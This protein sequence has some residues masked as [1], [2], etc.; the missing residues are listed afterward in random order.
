MYWLVQKHAKRMCIHVNTHVFRCTG[1]CSAELTKV[2]R[3]RQRPRLRSRRCSRSIERPQFSTKTYLAR[4]SKL[5][6]CWAMSSWSLRLGPCAGGSLQIS[7]VCLSGNLSAF[8][9]KTAIFPQTNILMFNI[10]T[11][12]EN[13][14][15]SCHP[16]P[17]HPKRR[18]GRLYFVISLD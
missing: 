16:S 14:V 9:R 17:C 11:E 18:P 15:K 7:N 2:L 13:K 1:L 5:P 3:T 10:I 4:L 12:N 6:G 8:W